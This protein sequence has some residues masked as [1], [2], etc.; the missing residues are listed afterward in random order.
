MRKAKKYLIREV[1]VSA[2]I[3]KRQLQNISSILTFGPQGF[4]DGT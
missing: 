3:W 1:G 2:E 4:V